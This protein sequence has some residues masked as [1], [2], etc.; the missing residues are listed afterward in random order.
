MK[1]LFFTFAVM[2]FTFPVSADDLQPEPL[3]QAIKEYKKFSKTDDV[4]PAN[5]V[6]WKLYVLFNVGSNA[7]YGSITSGSLFLGAASSGISSLVIFQKTDSYSNPDTLLAGLTSEP[8]FFVLLPVNNLYNYFRPIPKPG[9]VIVLKGRIS[10]HFNYQTHAGQKVFILSALNL[11]L[12][13]GKK[14]PFEHFDP[15]RDYSIMPSVTPAI[16]TPEP[17][18]ASMAGPTTTSTSVVFTPASPTAVAS[19]TATPGFFKSRTVNQ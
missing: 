10:G 5:D 14:L 13:D 8:D 17:V 12:E 9:D 7:S 2:L 4:D 18:P 11:Y 1:R 15:P 19:F 3:N 16:L 6:I